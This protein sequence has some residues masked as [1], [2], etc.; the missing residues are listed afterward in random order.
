[1]GGALRFV[2]GRQLDG[3]LEALKGNILVGCCGFPLPMGEYFQ[4]FPVV[5]IQQTFY[6]PP[7]EKTVMKWKEKA[8]EG[9]TFTLKAWQL[10][11]H[12]PSSPTYRRLR[13]SIDP[14]KRDRYG[15]FKP[16][17]EVM[18]AWHRTLTLALALEAKLVLFQCPASFGPTPENL[19]NMRKFFYTIPRE[20][21]YMGW[22]PRGKWPLDLVAFLCSEL[23][24]IHCVD[25][26][27]GLPVY[28]EI[29]YFRLHGITGYRYVFSEEDLKQLLSWCQDKATYVL[30]NNVSMANDALRFRFMLERA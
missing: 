17:Q 27:S 1:M 2:G 15:C 11:T 23:D 18:E 28:G 8:P 26:F 22:E 19:D 21:I 30:F 12:E 5:E 4:K 14:L 10:I 6:H 20:G 3:K 25:P 13:T 16:T 7:Q 29:N 9:F 24:L